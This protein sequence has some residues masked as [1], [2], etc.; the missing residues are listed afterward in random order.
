MLKHSGGKKIHVVNHSSP[1]LLS[2][3]GLS[4]VDKHTGRLAGNGS[5]SLSKQFC[6]QKIFLQGVPVSSQDW[7]VYYSGTLL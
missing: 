1:M 4:A 5:A 3:L 6:R 7:R 2:I